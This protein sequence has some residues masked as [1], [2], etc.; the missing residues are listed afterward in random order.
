MNTLNSLDDH[1]SILDLLYK[2]S[3][4]LEIIISC[5]KRYVR[6]RED[7]KSCYYYPTIVKRAT[8]KGELGTPE[9]ESWGQNVGLPWM[10]NSRASEINRHVLKSD[11]KIHPLPNLISPLR[12]VV[13]VQ[14]QPQPLL[15]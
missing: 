3:D 10:H 5:W 14:H 13:P 11:L 2:G 9:I 8:Q 6:K 4:G 7:N 1:V 12:L 15:I